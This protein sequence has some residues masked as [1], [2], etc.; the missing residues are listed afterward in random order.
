MADAAE[1][2]L[3]CLNCGRPLG[4]AFCS[5][6]GQK[7][8]VQRLTL[9][10]IFHDAFHAWAHMDSGFLRLIRELTVRPVRVMREYLAGR[11]KTYFSAMQ[12]LVLTMGLSAFLTVKFRLLMPAAGTTNE[13][14]VSFSEFTT[15][16]FNVIMF[17]AVPIQ[18]LFSRWLFGKAGYNYAE[19]LVVN[20]FLSG[21][22]ALF[23]SIVIAPLIIGARPAYFYWIGLYTL[24]WVVYTIW[25]YVGV[26]GGSR[27]LAGI[28]KSVLSIV[29][30]Y[31]VHYAVMVA[32]F[33]LHQRMAF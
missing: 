23:F 7:A 9:H 15:R 19:H 1:N 10:Q 29:L 12:Y 20:A 21:H 17:L 31:I 14:S 13:A 26:F 18:A 24:S 32:A 33:F 27:L 11:H 28:L 4:G 3:T 2:I 16:F 6:C 5:H 8:S 22:R 25:V 30:M